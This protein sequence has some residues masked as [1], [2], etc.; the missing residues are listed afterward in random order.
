METAQFDLTQ[1]ESDLIVYSLNNTWVDATN[2]LAG[3]D[4][5]DLE[6]KYLEQTRDQSK[7]LLM[8]IAAPF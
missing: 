1:N 3:K 8:K 2:K 6:R 5:G 4:L 7:I